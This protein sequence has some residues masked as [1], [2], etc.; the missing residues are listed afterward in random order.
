MKRTAGKKSSVAL[1]GASGKMG[2]E[3]TEILLETPKDWSLAFALSSKQVP[4]FS[5]VSGDFSDLQK[6]KTDLVIDFSS[7]EFFRKTIAHLK[8]GPRAFLSGTTGLE[9]E[10]HKLLRD[11]AKKAPVFWAPNT[12]LGV[13]TLKKAL[14]SLSALADYDFQVEEVHHRYK[15]DSP[16]GTAKLLK[17]QLD[18]VVGKESPAALAMRGGGVPGLHRVW[19]FGPEEW[20]CFEHMALQRKVF[21][22]GAVAIGRWLVKQKPGLYTMEDFLAGQ[23]KKMR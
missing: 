15:K 4:A 7:P 5:T 20:L 3:I 2:K 9:E 17:A 6:S 12:S 8:K 18:R 19:A 13:A 11:L 21:A 23:G 14:E 1:I 22:R 10:D 16:S